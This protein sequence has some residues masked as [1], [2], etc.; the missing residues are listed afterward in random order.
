MNMLE[1]CIGVC[2][3]IVLYH[4]VL[5]PFILSSLAYFAD[6]NRGDEIKKQSKN[7]SKTAP[8]I[9][10][11]IAAYNEQDHIAGKLFNIASQS[12]SHDKMA[13]HLFLDGCT[14]NTSKIANATAKQLLSERIYCKI[15]ECSENGGKV[16]AINFL[17]EHYAHLYDVIVLTDASALLSLNTFSRIA[18][19]FD[20]EK[21]HIVSGK[22]QLFD[23]SN[24]QQVRYW[25][26]QNKIRER[27]SKLG[28]VVGVAGAFF[29]I[30]QESIQLLPS[31]TINDDFIL[32]VNPLDRE[33]QA[34]IDQ[35]ISI[36]ELE[37][38]TQQQDITRRTR[39]GAGNWQQMMRLKDKY[40]SYSGWISFTFFSH[41]VL[42][43]WMPLV[44]LISAIS[45]ASLALHGHIVAIAA[46]LIGIL[47]LLCGMMK[48][49]FFSSMKLPVID[50]VNYLLANYSASLFGILLY[51]FGYYKTPWCRLIRPS[52]SINA[53]AVYKRVF[54]MVG[55]TFGI[56]LS[57][58]ILVVAGVAIKL[59][60]KGPIFYKQLRVGQANEDYIRLF[61]VYKL[62]TM[63]QNAEANTGA[64]WATAKDPRITPVGRFL[65]ATRIDEL[66]QFWNVIKGDMSLI[67][68]R[69]ERP[70]F[71]QKLESN[72][73]YFCHRTFLLKPGISGLAQ[74]MNGYDES[75]DD[76]RNKIAWDYAYSLSMSSFSSWLKMEALIILHTIKV[77]LLGKG[78]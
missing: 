48:T 72:I 38:D 19:N 62:R 32:S 76:V 27:E 17:I 63:F 71:Y 68:P 42:R 24:E 64:V 75:I 58:P 12:Y 73:P 74:V 3:L 4:H 54:D 78:Q 67:G 2:L 43:A 18:H 65:R 25:R 40:L 41:K 33:H 36:V 20:N 70:Q 29:A 8:K 28:A 50:Q 59:T 69:P 35:S 39:I 13:I 23:T 15:D 56:L 34:K 9:G 37:P 51:V 77:V 11:F 1:V 49:V 52:S 22:Y 66:P 5:Y 47:F 21:V 30:K 10:V 6:K 31:D 61:Y 55:A 14:D 46:V 7:H 60:S 53:V 57:F 26:Y 45:S 16:A 44:L